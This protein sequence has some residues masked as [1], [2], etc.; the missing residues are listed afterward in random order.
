M[1]RAEELGRMLGQTEEYK[2]LRRADEHLQS[3]G[4]ASSLLKDL[5]AKSEEIQQALAEEQEPDESV[6]KGYEQ[7][8]ERVQT[9]APYQRM[10]SA[11]ANFDKLMHKIN[12]EILQ[13]IKKGAESPI[14]TL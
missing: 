13:G 8:R 12:E 1:K 4:E 7:I 2:A 10:V 11:Q 9:L 3:D 14:I 6:M 5:Q